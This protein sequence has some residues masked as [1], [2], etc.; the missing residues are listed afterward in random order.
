MKQP[1]LFSGIGVD[2]Q[3]RVVIPCDMQASRNAHNT[4]RAI[5][6]A[7]IFSGGVVGQRHA[8]AFV[9]QRHELPIAFLSHDHTNTPVFTDH[10]NPVAGEVNGRCLTRRFS[11][12]CRTATAT[13]AA[14]RCRSN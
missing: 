8:I 12:P 7:R 3:R 11:R 14:L 9:V 6:F 1:G 5:S 10:G 13:L 2:V 4:G